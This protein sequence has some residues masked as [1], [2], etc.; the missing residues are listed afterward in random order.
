MASELLTRYS[1]LRDL[2]WDERRV[3]GQLARDLGVDFKTAGRIVR[4]AE[5][6]ERKAIEQARPR[7]VRG[8]GLAEGFAV[9]KPPNPRRH[10]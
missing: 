9:N 1:E 8:M 10:G 4:R 2:G 6:A 3:I 5:A 7:V